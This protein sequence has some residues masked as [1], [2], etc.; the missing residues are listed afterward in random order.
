MSGTPSEAPA[1]VNEVGCETSEGLLVIHPESETCEV[2]AELV[3]QQGSGLATA[4]SQ[5]RSSG[6]APLQRDDK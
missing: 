6:F 5:G 4:L 3:A 1:R 2:C